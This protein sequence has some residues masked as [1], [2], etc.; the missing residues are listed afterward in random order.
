L[1][2]LSEYSLNQKIHDAWKRLKV[3]AG[4]ENFKTMSIDTI[5]VLEKG[6]S[7]NRLFSHNF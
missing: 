1:N 6:L 3:S 5:S 4:E 2:E 7:I